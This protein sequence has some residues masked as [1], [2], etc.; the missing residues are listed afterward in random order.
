[1]NDL[2][3]TNQVSELLQVDRTTVYR[4]LKNG[5]LP[6]VKV[7]NQWRFPRQAVEAFLLGEMPQPPEDEKAD[8]SSH[9]LLPFTTMQ[10]VQDICAEVANIGAV[11]TDIDGKPLTKISNPSRFCQLVLD[12]DSG[13][14][15]CHASWREL[16][17]QTDNTS[18]FAICHAGLQCT[19]AFID[20][21][22]V[23]SAMLVAGQFYSSAPDPDQEAARIRP[24]AEKHHIDHLALQ[25]AAAQITILDERKRHEITHWLDKAVKTF[26]EAGRERAK[27]FD[28]LRRIVEISS[29]N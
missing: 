10:A 9:D 8:L 20:V 13:R 12:S 23:P 7:G 17:Q 2:L 14:C 26:A 21:V 4:L 18:V 11:V 5:R 22:G 15:A 1:M 24:L 27:M 29:I 28:R 16:A 6:G 19:R 25:E 3:T